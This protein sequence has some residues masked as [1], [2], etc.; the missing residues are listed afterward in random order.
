[1]G[2]LGFLALVLLSAYASFVSRQGSTL[3]SIQSSLNGLYISIMMILAFFIS[4]SSVVST[5]TSLVQE[6]NSRSLEMV[7]TTPVDLR[8]Y[9]LGRLLA[10]LRT[11][12]MGLVLAL[13]F[14]SITVLLGGFTWYE[15][16]STFI[17][18]SLHALIF[19]SIGLAIGASQVK[20][21]SA[22]LMGL[23]AVLVYQILAATGI[24]LLI[25]PSGVG[26]SNST[27]WIPCLNTF[28]APYAAS[29][30]SM[31]FGMSI[32]NTVMVAVVAV[33]LARFFLMSAS[34]TLAP[35]DTK[36]TLH[37]RVHAIFMAC[38]FGIYNA[39]TTRFSLFGAGGS[40]FGSAPNYDHFSRTVVIL[41]VVGILMVSTFSHDR[42][43]S[44]RN[45]LDGFFS[46]K[47]FRYGTPSGSLPFLLIMFLSIYAPQVITI[48]KFE[49]LGAFVVFGLYGLATMMFLW[50]ITMRFSLRSGIAIMARVFTYLF[51]VGIIAIPNII[52]MILTAY[53]I[54]PS[55]FDFSLVQPWRA[56]RGGY[57]PI[58]LVI[59][60]LV[61]GLIT[62]FAYTVVRKE[63]RRLSGPPIQF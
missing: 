6:K 23:F 56:I 12:C 46:W 49:D 62:F 5:A 60:T 39:M 15:V 13:P 41:F 21:G 29:Q 42:V 30:N 18:M 47:G 31:I 50:A 3:S 32:P 43:S 4:V 17:C 55:G 9:L 22:A 40:G 51:L 28:I 25:M 8:A 14:I 44:R 19:G 63:Y 1:M 11:T 35:S 58:D 2:Y 26:S 59:S 52:A 10:G 27:S 61:L 36:F 37:F 33:F 53:Q 48:K 38:S 16:V 45:M 24:A 57:W 7:L 54:L 34:S 20:E